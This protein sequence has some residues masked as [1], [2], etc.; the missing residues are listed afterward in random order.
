MNEDIE[1]EIIN[2]EDLPG[3]MQQWSKDL[4]Q[5]LVAYGTCFTEYSIDKD[6]KLQARVIPREDVRD[7]R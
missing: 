5:E 6:G 4:V 7:E 3:S 1:V 2:Q